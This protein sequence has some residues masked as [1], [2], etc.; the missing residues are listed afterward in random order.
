MSLRSLFQITLILAATAFGSHSHATET[1][2]IRYLSNALSEFMTANKNASTCFLQLQRNSGAFTFAKDAIVLNCVDASA[3]PTSKT[4]TAESSNMLQLAPPVEIS[5]TMA[6]Q[7][8]RA[9]GFTVQL[10]NSDQAIATK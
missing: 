3:Q 6:I 8:L 2:N 7:A 10:S 9:Q 1:D 5:F 4:L